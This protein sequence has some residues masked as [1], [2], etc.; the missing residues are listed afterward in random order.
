MPVEFLASQTGLSQATK[1][2]LPYTGGPLQLLFADF[3]LVLRCMPTALGIF[4]PLN[5]RNPDIRDEIYPGDWRNLFSLFLHV[6]LVFLQT[7]FLFSL[8]SCLFIPLAWFAIYV[9]LFM[10]L[11]TCICWFLNGS[12]IQLVSQVPVENEEKHASEY[13]VYMNGVSVG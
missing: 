11:N 8:I 1:D 10:L 6:V 3:L 4:L 2:P 9:G 7:T 12:S 13:W 5:F